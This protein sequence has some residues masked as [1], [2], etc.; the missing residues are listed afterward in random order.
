MY[1]L[2]RLHTCLTAAGVQGPKLL[3]AIGFRRHQQLGAVDISPPGQLSRQLE[4]DV[5]PVGWAAAFS[6]KA[7]AGAD[8]SDCAVMGHIA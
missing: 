7:A 3:T 8:T 2:Y 6:S 1:R 5:G 4:G